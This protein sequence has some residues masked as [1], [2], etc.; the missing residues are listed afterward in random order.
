MRHLQFLPIRVSVAAALCALVSSCGGGGGNNN[1]PDD[2]A[3]TLPTEPAP[4][5]DL[6]GT[7]DGLYYVWWDTA[8]DTTDFDQDGMLDDVRE[9][10]VIVATDR[11]NLCDDL[12]LAPLD[13][14][15][16][17]DFIRIE[18]NALFI[19]GN[20]AIGAGTVL[21]DMADSNVTL[22]MIARG[23]DGVA[24]IQAYDD[25][26]AILTVDMLDDTT[27]TG[28][29]TGGSIVEAYDGSRMVPAMPTMYTVDL[30]HVPHCTDLL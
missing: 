23:D 11:A 13:D 19:D 17:I 30:L 29:V 9:T 28:S 5:V 10:L 2:W 4:M 22:S 18:A 1:H 12:A 3:F 14:F 26:M 15:V 7:F 24:V 20:G 16:G 6:L 21:G 8:T 27:L 25:G